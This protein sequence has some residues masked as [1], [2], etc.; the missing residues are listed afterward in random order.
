MGATGVAEPGLAAGRQRRGDAPTR[1]SLSAGPGRLCGAR[2]THIDERK[3]HCRNERVG[4]ALFALAAV[5]ASQDE[6]AA[7]VAACADV[8]ASKRKPV[9]ATRRSLTRAVGQLRGAASPGPS[10]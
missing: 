4:A 6:T 8:L 1:N 3:K 9:T 5:E 10:G 7:V 2:N